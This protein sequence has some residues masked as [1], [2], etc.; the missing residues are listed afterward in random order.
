[1][2]CRLYTSRV[3]QT[4]NAGNFKA[5]QQLP[6]DAF[7]KLIELPLVTPNTPWVITC[8][9]R[10]KVYEGGDE[11][12]IIC[13]STVS[14]NCEWVTYHWDNKQWQ[15]VNPGPVDDRVALV[16]SLINDKHQSDEKIATLKAE[17]SQQ[18]LENMLLRH[19][20]E[21]SRRY[22]PT[23]RKVNWFLVMVL[24]AICFCLSLPTASAHEHGPK[25]ENPLQHFPS[26]EEFLLRCREKLGV[27]DAFTGNHVIQWINYLASTWTW[28]IIVLVLTTISILTS[29]NPITSI[30]YLIACSVTSWK[31]ALLSITPLHTMSSAW[32]T[33]FVA[34]IYCVDPYVGVTVAIIQFVFS[35]LAGLV[36][37]DEAFIVHLKA[38]LATTFMIVCCHI[39]TVLS[40]DTAALGFFVLLWRASQLLPAT[41][42]ATL[43]VRNIEGKSVRKLQVTPGFLFRFKQKARSVY[44]QLR[45]N[46]VPMVRVQPAA[47]CMVH[48]GGSSGTGFFAGNYIITA[49][50]VVGNCNSV[51]IRYNGADYCATVK[52]AFEGRD[53][54]LI[55]TPHALQ[56][57]PKY[58]IAKKPDYT[59][60]C[61]CAPDNEG[62]FVT[63]TTPGMSHDD[64]ISYATPTKNGMSGAP[65]LDANGHVLGVHQTN[66]GFTGGAVIIRPDD[67]QDVPR[68]N[69]VKDENECLRK[70]LEELKKQLE[71]T[72]KSKVLEQCM[73]DGEIV[74]LVRCAIAR[75][76]GILRAELNQA[77]GKTK[78]GRGALRLKPKRA[79]RNAAWTE[80]EYKEL[81]SKGLDTKT[82][83]RM[84]REIIAN[85]GNIHDEDEVGFPTW[86]D[87]ELSEGSVDTDFY[88]EELEFGQNASEK[89]SDD[90]A[91]EIPL[92]HDDIPDLTDYDHEFDPQIVKD[93]LKDTTAADRALLA[94]DL[95]KVYQACVNPSTLPLALH[96]LD[97]TA[98]SYGLPLFLERV[99]PKNLKRAPKEGPKLQVTAQVHEPPKEQRVKKQK[100]QK[101]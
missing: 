21:R 10:S 64:T 12:R 74:D 96:A 38:H 25:F 76:M 46:I 98:Q 49:A 99:K 87:P 30:L 17:L 13:A 26:W 32:T 68:P 3:D 53:I 55:V 52:K 4:I 88:E 37:S 63:T 89:L 33:V 35:I 24:V 61:V 83:R 29:N 20:V 95:N 86:S 22:E 85:E 93:A 51:T 8:P 19:D 62:A 75:E 59:W 97:C 15:R 67:I 11:E 73:D 2:A 7:A 40:I 28:S 36:L 6:N 39:C 69:P 27:G 82:L 92:V 57:V 14:T 81:L 41:A 1:M 54:C 47:L 56:T 79:R 42:G 43:E 71:E 48:A 90:I 44:T 60:V 72:K 78:H 77:K 66:T 16:A 34:F 5:R 65:V 80:E 50:H 70:Q 23:P 84:A 101:K 58:K 45:T 31:F 18:H 91:T 94:K 9:T 100:P